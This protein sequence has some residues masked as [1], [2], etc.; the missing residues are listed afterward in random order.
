[1]F[2]FS[3]HTTCLVYVCLFKNKKNSHDNILFYDSYNTSWFHTKDSAVATYQCFLDKQ[4]NIIYNSCFTVN[5][6]TKSFER[7]AGNE[8]SY[9]RANSDWAHVPVRVR[10]HTLLGCLLSR[11]GNLRFMGKMFPINSNSSLAKERPL[12]LIF[13]LWIHLTEEAC[14]LL[15]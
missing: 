10:G 8:D 1:M 3:F 9:Q 7:P 6:V 11:N 2:L 15:S 12:D 13:C 14:L 4:I 5:L